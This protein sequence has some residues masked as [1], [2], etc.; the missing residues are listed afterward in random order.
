MGRG[1][2]SNNNYYPP[3]WDPSQGGLNAWQGKH[4]LGARARKLH[5][6]ILVV[7]FEMPFP[8]RCAGCRQRIGQ[9]V[10][11]NADKKQHGAYHSTK[12][13]R[14]SMPCPNCK[15]R[16]E[17]QTD[18]KNATYT[19]EA[20]AT[21]V[22]TEP[23]ASAEERG[24]IDLSGIQVDEYGPPPDKFTKLEREARDRAIA[25]S[26]KGALLALKSLRREQGGDAL[27]ATQVVRQRFREQKALLA[28]AED[29]RLER[30][31]RGFTV[32]LLPE[33]DQDRAAASEVGFGHQAKGRTQHRSLS[34]DLHRIQT[35]SIFGKPRSTAP[36]VTGKKAELLRAM[37]AARRGAGKGRR[38][39]L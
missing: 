4:A 28:T 30:E 10:R 18:P 14:F 21:P 37:V 24:V 7:R 6:G 9:G 31:A 11:F 19:I 33:T 29:Q 2:Q 23:S 1:N 8:V 25:E 17:I 39:G 32:P 34:R 13:W 36:A 27:S 15:H 38:G 35:S 22:V 26:R 3:E 16:I 20:G 5:E 12:I